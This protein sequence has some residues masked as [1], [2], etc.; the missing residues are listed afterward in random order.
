LLTDLRTI[1]PRFK[2]RC[3]VGNRQE[4]VGRRF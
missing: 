3:A 4:I 2:R 1:G